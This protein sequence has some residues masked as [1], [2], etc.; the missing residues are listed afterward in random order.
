[1]VLKQGLTLALAGT[2][3]GVLAALGVTRYGAS[4][5]Y[6][7]NPTDALT[8]VVVP[9]FLVA[10]AVVSCMLPARV[11]SRVDSAEVLRGE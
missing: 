5:L 6:G 9:L 11:A 8:F 2:A 3:A 1:M 7:V 4:L 10:V